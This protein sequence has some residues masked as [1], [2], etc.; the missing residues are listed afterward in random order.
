M[1]NIFSCNI[2]KKTIVISIKMKLALAYA[3]I[4]EVTNLF[5]STKDS[6]KKCFKRLFC[7]KK[8]TSSTKSIV[9]LKKINRIRWMI[10]LARI[11]N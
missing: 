4:P 7:C 6:L 9:K 8:Y 5:D 11:F 1:Y 2:K 10:K 3:S